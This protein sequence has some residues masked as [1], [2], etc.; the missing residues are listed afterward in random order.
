MQRE[1]KLKKQNPTLRNVWKKTASW[2]EL[3]GANAAKWIVGER[4][5][6]LK[7][8]FC[9]KLDKKLIRTILFTIA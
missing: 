1:R 2:L 8:D 5:G 9:I 4:R 3:T 7:T 6:G